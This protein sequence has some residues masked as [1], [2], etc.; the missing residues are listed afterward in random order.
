[1]RQRLGII[2][3]IVL[4]VGVLVA[5]NSA[6]YVTEEKKPDSELNPDRSTYNAGATGTR[7]LHDFLNESGYQV[8]RWR[9]PLVKLLG[10]GGA[11]VRTF[12]I[13][14]RPQVSVEEEE[15][16]TLLLWVERGGRLVIVDRRPDDQLLPLSGEWKVTTEFLDFAVSADPAQV[17]QM[18]EG[19]KPVA[20]SQPTLLTRDVESVM[21]SRYF[22][23]I[24]FFPL[25][26]DKKKK[27]DQKISA[28]E[29]ASDEEDFGEDYDDPTRVRTS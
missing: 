9:E 14:G 11:K 12:V 16:Q 2:L 23:A 10:T 25:S 29:P 21:P 8:M 5:I 15:A 13:I 22:A 18:T 17:S 4:A 19:V 28:N 27:P 3:T 26:K 7:A 20:T 1:M 6:A 24:K